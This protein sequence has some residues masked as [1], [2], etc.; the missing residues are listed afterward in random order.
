MLWFYPCQFNRMTKEMRPSH[1]VDVLS[2]ALT[3]YAKDKLSE[4]MND[5]E[6]KL[7]YLLRAALP[8]LTSL[9]QC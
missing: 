6:L 2:S 5:H 3:Y 9:L 1:R 7:S 4:F 8:E